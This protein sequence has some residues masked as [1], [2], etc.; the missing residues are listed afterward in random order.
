LENHEW[1]L[2][3]FIAWLKVDLSILVQAK[4]RQSAIKD[5]ENDLTKSHMHKLSA[6]IVF[7]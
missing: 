6:E 4:N 1:K 3:L 5:G 7:L 2:G